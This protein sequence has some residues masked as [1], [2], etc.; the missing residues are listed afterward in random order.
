MRLFITSILVLSVGMCRAQHWSSVLQGAPHRDE[1]FKSAMVDIL[2]A[3][4]HD[5]AT[6][7]KRMESYHYLDT[8]WDVNMKL[9][10]AKE[11]KLNKSNGAAI[12]TE[13][14]AF[15]DTTGLDRL[16]QKIK[17]SLPDDYVYSLDYDPASHTYDYTFEPNPLSKVK[18]TGYPSY[19]HMTGDTETVFLFIGLSPSSLIN[20]R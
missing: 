16:L 20:P 2:S 4:G 17:A 14:F 19:L 15:T 8:I 3:A 1:G 11:A 10:G 13:T 6:V 5:F 12:L 7:P 9:P 18:H